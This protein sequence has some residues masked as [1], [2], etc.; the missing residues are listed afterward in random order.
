M[1]D[2]DQ[3]DARRVWAIDREEVDLAVITPF[4]DDWASV[5]RVGTADVELHGFFAKAPG[6]ALDTVDKT[7]A[8][9]HEVA[10]RVLAKR[11]V[12]AVTEFAQYGNDRERRAIADVLRMLHV[13]KLADASAGPCPAQT[14]FKVAYHETSAGV[15]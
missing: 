9:E 15:A 3:I 6:L 12:D 13:A 1:A 8:F 4:L 10:T 14:T 7:V 11:Q 2:R 5:V